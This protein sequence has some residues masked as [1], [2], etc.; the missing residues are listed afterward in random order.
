MGEISLGWASELREFDFYAMV[1]KLVQR[2][3]MKIL[4]T[5]VS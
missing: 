4:I 1:Q 3:D 5:Q 2:L